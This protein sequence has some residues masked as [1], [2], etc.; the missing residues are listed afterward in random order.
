MIMQE[1][2]TF[3]FRANSHILSLLGDELIGTDNLAIFEL[4]KNAYDADA[5]I[6]KIVFENINT[7]DAK[8]IVEDNG[9]GMSLKTVETSWL[10][11]GTSFKRGKN[12]VPSKKFGR[13]SLGEKG[14]G[15]LAVHKL[16]SNIILETKEA[17]DLF[18]STLE[19]NWSDLMSKAKYIEDT[20]VV[21][22]DC[23]RN[24]FIDAQHGTRITLAN[25]RRRR[26]EKKEIR[27]L[28][29][30]VNTL[31]SPFDTQKDNF[32]VELILPTEYQP[33]I[34][35]IFNIGQII[36]SATYHF[37]FS[38]DV[39]GVYTWNYNFTPPSIFKLKTDPTSNNNDS[40][41]DKKLILYSNKKNGNLILS[42]SELAGIGSITG[43]LHVFNLVSEVLNTF[44]Q[45]KNIKDYLKEN[46]GVRVYRDGIRVYNYGESGNDW[47]GLDV[48]RTNNPGAKFGN[49]TILGTINLNLKDSTR[50]KE[51][52]NREGF[53]ENDTYEIFKNICF[54]IVSHAAN[55]AQ[56]DRTKLDFAI[57]KDRKVNKVGFS[58]TVEE[59]KKLIVKK[60]LQTEL[61]AAVLKVEQDYTEMRDV[62]LNSGMAGLNLSIV[63]HELER[64]V[65]YINEDIKRGSNIEL[66][67]EKVRNVM[68]L[69]DGFSPIL[70][71]QN[72]KAE[73]IS[74]IVNRVKNLSQSRLIYHNIILSS[75]L[76]SDEAED[77]QVLAQTNL[78]VSAINNII[79][80]SIYWTR[81][82]Q[83]KTGENHKPFIYISTNT[84][85]FNGPTLIIGDNGDG[86]KLPS[87]ELTRPF[88]TTRPGG[89][90]LGL[91]YASM[92]M[93]LAGGK[94]LFIDPKDYELPATITGAV[95]ALVFNNEKQ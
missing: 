27:S 10:E 12:R 19:I 33:W 88:V 39:N 55:V 54:S 60:N 31:I 79:D 25:L 6:V 57:K 66:I 59:L 75:P 20:E 62:M 5:T 38:I 29:R 41:E 82:K 91:Y 70:K 13:I 90:G 68:L 37:K 17:N 76:L 2:H 72:R 45:T 42:S 67:S 14:V 93:E 40:I 71:Q 16:A 22:K 32:V 50:L 4:V 1:Q 7:P 8:I 11:I 49:N 80:N 65:R 78:L 34:N 53:D 43:E 81:V 77:F 69:L 84:K 63:F 92:V 48:V 30:T 61:G 18:G 95:I 35:D 73:N 52:T 24:Q 46:A 9:C 3:S 85:D 74:S 87:D 94:I 56:Q 58:E 36:Q 21:V 83:E 89:M 15:R 51:K 23:E 44:N 26:W 28:A 64:E 47:M 86:F